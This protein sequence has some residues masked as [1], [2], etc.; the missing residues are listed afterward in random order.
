MLHYL[1]YCLLF[2]FFFV[3]ALLYS[4]F[5]LFH[6]IPFD[7]YLLLFLILGNYYCSVH[8]PQP[9]VTPTFDKV[10]L[11]YKLLDFHYRLFLIK[12]FV[13][14]YLFAGIIDLITHDLIRF[15][16]FFDLLARLLTA[17]PTLLVRVMLSFT[18]PSMFG[19]RN[20]LSN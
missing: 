11:M 16:F 7:S 17:Y 19:V 9:Q 6:T 2:C 1:E 4:L 15:N 13:F 5:L 10:I 14:I 3:F 8:C 20:L 12:P 18:L